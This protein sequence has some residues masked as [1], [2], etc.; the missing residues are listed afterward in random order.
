ME[1]GNNE[2]TDLWTW[3]V[4]IS[5]LDL[6]ERFSSFLKSAFVYIGSTIGLFTAGLTPALTFGY[7]LYHAL[8]HI[9][10]WSN[11]VAKSAGFAL[12]I[13]MEVV[14]SISAY[15]MQKA[16]GTR[17]WGAGFILFV[18]T[19]IGVGYMW[20]FEQNQVVRQISFVGYLVSLLV[21]IVVPLF[22]STI[23]AN[24]EKERLARQLEKE[25]IEAENKAKEDEQAKREQERLANEAKQR[26]DEQDRLFEFN[27]QQAELKWQH[28]ERERQAQRDHE[29][30]LRQI[31]ANEKVKLSRSGKKVMESSGKVS[32]KVVSADWRKLPAEDKELIAKMTKAQVMEQYNVSA[33]TASNWLKNALQISEI[34]EKVSVNGNG[35]HHG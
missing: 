25:A 34:S 26:Q 16:D 30:R 7:S 9:D 23:E 11:D 32:G 15:V 6:V 31:E 8:S 28:E 2:K 4:S 29:A 17:A 18:Y 13:T 1:Q 33:K 24:K 19:A 35:V 20:K 14:G 5:W 3:F 22:T 21:Y 12:A 27:K 10:G